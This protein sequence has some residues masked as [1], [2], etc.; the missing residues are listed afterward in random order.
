MSATEDKSGFC[1]VSKYKSSTG[2]KIHV[3]SPGNLAGS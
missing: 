1:F 3:L 2:T